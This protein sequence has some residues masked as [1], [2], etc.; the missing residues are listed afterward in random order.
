MRPRAHERREL[1]GW[2]LLVLVYGLVLSPLFHAVVTHGGLGW[3]PAGDSL[4]RHTSSARPSGHDESKP[5][6]HPGD[7]DEGSAPSHTHFTG[8]LE[9]HATAFIPAVPHVDAAP[10]R[11]LVIAIAV[12]AA[13]RS[14]G[15]PDWLPGMPQGP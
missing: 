5:H 2:G 6:E 4:F 3:G 15:A 14:G 8:S 7:S 12:H 11:L 10:R 13:R 1:G 9:H